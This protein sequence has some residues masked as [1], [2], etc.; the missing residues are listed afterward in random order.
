[1]KTKYNLPHNFDSNNLEFD[2][3][4]DVMDESSYREEVKI[5]NN[6]RISNNSVIFRYFKIIKESCISEKVYENYSKGYKFFLKFIFPKINFHCNKRFIL[7]TDEW[8]TNYYHWHLIALPRLLAIKSQNLI[9]NSLL[10]LPKKYAKITFVLYGLEKLGINKSQIV[11]LRRK[12][13]IKVKELAFPILYLNDQKTLR[14]LKE[15]LLK[16]LK[17]NVNFGEKIY[18]SRDGQALRFV[19]NEKDFVDLVERYGFKK[20]LMEKFSYEDQMSICANAKYIIG[21][22][23]AGLTNILF[24]PED[25]CFLELVAKSEPIKPV[26]DYYRMAAMCG[27]KYFYQECKTAGERRDFHHG[28][29]IADL[30]KLEKNLLMML[31]K[32]HLPN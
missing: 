11:Y 19:E 24:M 16:D 14:T 30:D 8:T 4:K 15:S 3:F 7:I 31:S 22:H 27:I 23:G 21:P 25:G 1:M 18:I 26:T 29:L 28:S 2:I 6:V 32:N 13:N 9:K 5:F 10:L 12:S 17:N 20:V